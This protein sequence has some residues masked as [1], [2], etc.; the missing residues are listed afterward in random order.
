LNLREAS[1]RFRGDLRAEARSGNTEECR[2]E[3]TVGDVPKA[4]A[5]GM[6]IARPAAAP[7]I[8]VR[9][10]EKGRIM[11]PCMCKKKKIVEGLHSRCAE[12]ISWAC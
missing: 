6:D 1:T 11:R 7:R 5:P 8:T 2:N 9:M 4:R 3:V 10:P 12:C